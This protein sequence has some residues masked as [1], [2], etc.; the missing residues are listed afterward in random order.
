MMSATYALDSADVDKISAGMLATFKGSDMITALKVPHPSGL[1][2]FAI[3]LKDIATMTFLPDGDG[4][5][6]LEKIEGEDKLVISVCV[7]LWV[8]KHTGKD[9]PNPN[10]SL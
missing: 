5:Y 3:T 7:N 6:Q 10:I 9:W 2:A 8:K 1:T 4:K